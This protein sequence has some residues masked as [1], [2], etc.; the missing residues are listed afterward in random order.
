MGIDDTEYAVYL[1]NHK[2]RLA[3][4]V[5][6]VLTPQESLKEEFSKEG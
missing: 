6:H 3:P 1:A 5:W 4:A 2:L